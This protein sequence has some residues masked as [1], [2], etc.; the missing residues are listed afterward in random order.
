MFYLELRHYEGTF[1]DLVIKAFLLANVSGR[2]GS[3]TELAPQTS[4]LIVTHFAIE[5]SF[6]VLELNSNVKVNFATMFLMALQNLL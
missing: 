4:T 2:G 1:N 3:G 6:R 5:L